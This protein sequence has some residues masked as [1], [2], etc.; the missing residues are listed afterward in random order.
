[1]P[2]RL[3]YGCNNYPLQRYVSKLENYLFLTSWVEIKKSNPYGISTGATLGRFSNTAA[4]SVWWSTFCSEGRIVE[5]KPWLPALAQRHQ[6]A[7][8]NS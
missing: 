4:V 6:R 1:M 3:R 8:A 2:I 5:I 7:S